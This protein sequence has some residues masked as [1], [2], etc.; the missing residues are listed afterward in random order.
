MGFNSGFKGLTAV[1]MQQFVR[2]IFFVYYF[3]NVNFLYNPCFIYILVVTKH[4]TLKHYKRSRYEFNKI[5]YSFVYAS[6]PEGNVWQTWFILM[7]VT[8]HFGQI[9]NKKYT[10]NSV[11]RV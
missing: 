3:E 6:R 4:Y 7:H 10:H 11:G 5:D 1:G 8:T 2:R 9:W